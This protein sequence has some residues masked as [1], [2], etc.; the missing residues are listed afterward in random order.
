MVKDESQCL[1]FQRLPL[2]F[3]YHLCESQAVDCGR[4]RDWFPSLSSSSFNVFESDSSDCSRF[5][6]I[7][8]AFQV[9]CINLI[10]IQRILELI[11]EQLV[12][13]S[14]ISQK[15]QFSKRFNKTLIDGRFIQF[16]SCNRKRKEKVK[17]WLNFR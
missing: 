10:Q 9:D 15:F 17:N 13:R 1:H 7:R 5:A 2:V 14:A 6:M 16:C 3:V 8:V 4:D 11:S 12:D